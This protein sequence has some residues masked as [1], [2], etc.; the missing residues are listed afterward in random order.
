MA[1]HGSYCLALQQT[2]HLPLGAGS[3]TVRLLDTLPHFA[4]LQP[5]V[6]F[7]LCHIQCLGMPSPSEASQHFSGSAASG[8]YGQQ[9]CL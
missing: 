1:V 6:M 5:Q 2:K 3:Q 4:I 9:L 7:L 8:C